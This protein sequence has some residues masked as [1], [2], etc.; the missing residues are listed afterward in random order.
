MFVRLIY[1]HTRLL[2]SLLFFA[3]ISCLSSAAPCAD[4]VFLT[5]TNFVFTEKENVTVTIPFRI[6]QHSPICFESHF[7][8][9][10]VKRIPPS[11]HSVECILAH[12][13]GTCQQ[14]EG[15]TKCTCPSDEKGVY[16]FKHTLHRSDNPPTEWTWSANTGVIRERTVTF[17]VV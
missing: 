10:V 11:L 2:R 6:T 13:N 1:L 16:H 4:I 14:P 7:L 17:I 9:Q 5:M 8:L 15:I 12:T 3:Q